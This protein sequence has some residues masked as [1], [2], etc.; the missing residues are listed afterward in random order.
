M[1]PPLPKKTKAGSLADNAKRLSGALG[2]PV[3]V[4]QIR[5]WKRVGYDLHDIEALKK[6]L[7]NQERNPLD[8]SR[9]KPTSPVVDSEEINAETVEAK[10][11]A[12]SRDL[13]AAADYAE[14]RTIATKIKGLKDV[15][16]MLREQGH[17][18]RHSEAIAAAS[19]AAIASKAA[20]EELEDA[21]PP[22][23]EG[24]TAAKMKLQIRDFSRMKCAELA[25]VFET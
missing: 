21:L 10:I 5:Q 6:S 15:L 7:R 17:Y 19:K 20:W 23:L 25:E 9:I 16:T 4:E 22:Q 12:L 24:L 2:I 8:V 18:M 1:P 3:T 11:E 14:A 13:L